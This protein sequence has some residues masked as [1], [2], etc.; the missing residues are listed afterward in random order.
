MEKLQF[1]GAA[2]GLFAAGTLMVLYEN[3][4]IKWAVQF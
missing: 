4:R 2:I 1:F 3:L